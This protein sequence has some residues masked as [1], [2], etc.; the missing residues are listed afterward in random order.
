MVIAVKLIYG[1]GIGNDLMDG[2]ELM[3][4]YLVLPANGSFKMPYKLS[5]HGPMNSSLN[6]T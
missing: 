5:R 1:T 6:S 2:A 4:K 3:N